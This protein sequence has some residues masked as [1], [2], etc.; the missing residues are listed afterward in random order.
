MKNKTPEEILV[1]INK[2]REN[3]NLIK[4]EKVKPLSDYEISRLPKI[5]D[6]WNWVLINDL[7]TFITNG[8]HTPTGPEDTNGYGLHCLRITDIQG[9][10]DI[11]YHQL[12]YCLRIVSGDYDKKLRKGDIYFSFTGNNLGKRFIV[13][14]DR[15]DTVY[16]H[17]FVRWHPLIVNPY[18]VYYVAH[19]KV[20]DQFIY[21]RTLGST[22]PNLKVTDLKRFPI[23]LCDLE[24]QN[25]IANFLKNIDDKISCNKAINRNLLD[26]LQAIFNSWFYELEPFGGVEPEGTKYVSI[27]ELCSVVTKGTT[28]TTLGMNFTDAGVNYIK[29]E[30]ILNN[31]GFDRSKLSFVSEDTHEKLKRSQVESGD[32]VFTIAGTLGRFALVDDSMVPANTNQAVAIIRANKVSSNYL[33]SAY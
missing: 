10:A 30:T 3:E 26:Q 1:E 11:N 14:E 4:D 18:Y 33:V 5:P 19:S 15:E 6:N 9:D 13:K 31:H 25:K 29:G 2:L 28:P 24:T 12:P 20:Y 16:A 22:Q 21:E 7:S 17:Y 8:V 23:P 27:K 32:I